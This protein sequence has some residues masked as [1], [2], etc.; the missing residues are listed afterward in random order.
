MPVR[1][2]PIVGSNEVSAPILDGTT[3]IRGRRVAIKVT[4]VGRD[5]NTPLT[6]RRALVGLEIST[7]F[8]WQQMPKATRR[9]IPEGSRLAYVMEVI[10]RLRIAKK[11]GEADLLKEIAPGSFDLYVFEPEIFIVSDET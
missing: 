8:S 3:F 9:T 6:I 10:E 2:T 5:T 11:T 4:G 7:I 1:T